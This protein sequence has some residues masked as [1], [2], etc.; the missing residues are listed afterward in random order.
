MI[1]LIEV[2]YLLSNVNSD[3]YTIDVSGFLQ[4]IL[5]CGESNLPTKPGCFLSNDFFV[6][7]CR[8]VF[9]DNFCRQ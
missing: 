5:L 1:C 9:R 7:C 2:E 8:T 4:I 3:I 6:D